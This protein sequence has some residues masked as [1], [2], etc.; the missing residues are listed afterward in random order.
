MSEMC[1]KCGCPIKDELDGDSCWCEV[2]VSIKEE[3]PP[4]KEALHLLD[5]KI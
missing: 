2:K 4:N 3:G 5:F 1:P